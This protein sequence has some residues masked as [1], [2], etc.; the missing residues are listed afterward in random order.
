[1][2][3]QIDIPLFLR[4]LTGGVTVASVNGSNVGDC[5]NFLVAQFPETRGLLFKKDGKL[6]DHIDVHINGMT[7]YPEELSRR[8][9]DGDEISILY[10]MS[11]G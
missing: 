1:M 5:L 8:V 2:T 7:A 6:L 4:H 10:L 3:V 9:D 11:G